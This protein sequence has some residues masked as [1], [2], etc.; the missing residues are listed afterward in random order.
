M[1]VEFAEDGCGKQR[2]NGFVA[3]NDKRCHC[4]SPLWNGFVSCGLA[5]AGEDLFSAKLFSDRR[6]H[7]VARI[8]IGSIG[9]LFG[10]ARPTAMR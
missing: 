2:F 5:Y 3:E 1:A 4:S 7:D 9:L 6:K 8:G 10:L